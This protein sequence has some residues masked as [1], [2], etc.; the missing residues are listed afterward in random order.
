MKKLIV[1]VCLSLITVLGFS[2]NRIEV[3]AYTVPSSYGFSYDNAVWEP[4]PGAYADWRTITDESDYGSITLHYR[5]LKNA[6]DVDY[7]NYFLIMEHVEIA[8]FEEYQTGD[9][10]WWSNSGYKDLWLNGGIM[11]RT[12]VDQYMSN[13]ELYEYSPQAD[14]Q[15]YSYSTSTTASLDF[16]LE[17]NSNGE[18]T[19]SL[20][21]G[22]SAT[23][24]T[25]WTTDGR[26]V[27]NFSVS[28]SDVVKTI[29]RY[30]VLE[31]R[32]WQDVYDFTDLGLHSKSTYW[33]FPSLGPDEDLIDNFQQSIVER[34]SYVIK[35]PKNQ[36]ILLNLE[37]YY[38]QLYFDEAFIND[39][40]KTYFSNNKKNVTIYMSTC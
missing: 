10:V 33:N 6:Q 25:S 15:E 23:A 13:A 17:A 9:T 19:T 16:G 30:D 37:V 22:I 8:L 14:L 34:Q 11:L 12:D 28:S 27:E 40:S 35:V 38:V 29:Y 2:F 24:S 36:T 20:G 18:V 21:V 3:E 7:Y 31:N 39:W 32:N 5:I 1:L 26:Y 4:C